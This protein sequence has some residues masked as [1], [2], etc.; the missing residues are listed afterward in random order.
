MKALLPPRRLDGS[1]L[2]FEAAAGGSTYHAVGQNWDEARRKAGYPTVRL[3]DIRHT[4]ATELDA[5]GDRTAMK[6]ALGMSD[7][8]VARYAEHRRFDRSVALF[9][10][11]ESRH[12]FGT[13]ANQGVAE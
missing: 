2:V 11:Y 12:K 5:L 13:R 8:T 4:V 1:A 3:H 9:D 7:P 6:S 10:K